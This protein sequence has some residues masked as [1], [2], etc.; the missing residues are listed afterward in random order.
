M[1]RIALIGGHG[2]VALQLARILTERGDDVSSVF[3]NPDHA[4][5]VAATGAEPVTADIERLDTDALAGLLAGHDAVVFSA[6]AG[7]GNPA[8][9]YA[10]DRDAAIRVIDAAAQ[11]G[12]TRFVMVSYFGAGPDHGVPQ[13]DPFFA[14]AEA[15]AAADAHLRAS[16][17]DWTVLGPGRLTLE[18]ATGRIALGEGKGSVSRADVAHVAAAAL[19]DDS[20]IGRTI[21]FNNGDVPI[22]QALAR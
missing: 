6:G 9:T 15:K 13:D 19:A 2:K 4:G 8:R 10:V 5:D 22:A 3:R 7:G 21:E 11:A 20:T 1:A 16:D 14:Y 12:V 17:L 18:P